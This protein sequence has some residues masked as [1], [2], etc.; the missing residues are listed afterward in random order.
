MKPSNDSSSENHNDLPGIKDADF[1]FYIS[2]LQSIRCSKGSTIAYAAHCQ[3]DIVLNRC[4]SIQILNSVLNNFK[5]L[6][7]FLSKTHR[8]TCK[9]LSGFDLN[10]TKRS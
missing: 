10:Q 5:K 7:I 1:V 6:P 4:V 3:Q 2:T 9:H 8:W